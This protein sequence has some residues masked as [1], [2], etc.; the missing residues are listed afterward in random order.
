MFGEPWP[1]PDSPGLFALPNLSEDIHGDNFQQSFFDAMSPRSPMM[2]IVKP[3]IVEHDKE[4]HKKQEVEKV[5]KWADLDEL[6]KLDKLRAQT[7]FIQVHT[8]ATHG[9]TPQGDVARANYVR[10]LKQ[11]LMCFLAG[12]RFQ[13]IVVPSAA[14]NCVSFD[15]HNVKQF[16]DGKEVGTATATATGRKRKKIGKSSSALCSIPEPPQAL[17]AKLPLPVLI[18]IPLNPGC[19]PA[20]PQ[21]KLYGVLTYYTP[22]GDGKGHKRS[23]GKIWVP[24][25]QDT[26]DTVW[27]KM[28]LAQRI[29]CVNKEADSSVKFP[30][31]FPKFTDTFRYMVWLPESPFFPKALC[32]MLAKNK[33]KD[34]KP[35]PSSASSGAKGWLISPA[36]TTLPNPQVVS[37]AAF[38]GS[39]SNSF[40][41]IPGFDDSHCEYLRV[42]KKTLDVCDKKTRK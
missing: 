23:L 25:N 24:R 12:E 13:V 30:W 36:N 26:I 2:Q 3:K 16:V 7:A 29:A 1:S 10:L 32:N 27:R 37:V 35:K 41:P 9:K 21:D 4:R 38:A 19:I 20:C 15:A 33:L 5:N 31:K 42:T 6:E 40:Q 8:L 18:Y 17:P 34:F 28:S 39:A 14:E 11:M 22:R